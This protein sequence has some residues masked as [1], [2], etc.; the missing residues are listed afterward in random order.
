MKY[1][2]Y[3]R[4]VQHMATTRMMIA[5][6]Y[7]FVSRGKAV[8]VFGILEFTNRRYTERQRTR[9]MPASVTMTGLGISEPAVGEWHPSLRKLFIR[10][11]KI[12]A[13]FCCDRPD[14]KHSAT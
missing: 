4:H 9:F 12:Q 11:F 7:N 14:L 3:T 8:D 6:P 10:G 5:E 1:R 2:A 13:R